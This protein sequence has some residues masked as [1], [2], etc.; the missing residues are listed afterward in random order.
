MNAISLYSGGKDGTFALYIALQQGL[1]V[2]RLVTINPKNR[3][4][5]MYHVPNVEHTKNI[6]EVIGIPLDTFYIEDSVEELTD[7]LKN[8]DSKIVI[9]G[10][11]KSEFQK[12]KIEKICTQLNK[13]SYT[14]LWYKDEILLIQ[15]IINSGFEVYISS[16]SAEGLGQEFLGAKF[17]MALLSK[18]IKLN[19]KYK[20]NISGEGGE[21]ETIALNAPFFKKRLI[22]KEYDKEW[23]GSSGIFH[24]KKLEI[25]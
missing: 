11:I 22:V 6:A 5:V 18:L 20:I 23:Q 17:D 7:L 16:V 24:I 13:I 4:S 12:T 8:Y 14:P 21:Y 3:E 19:E 2:D 9:S 25:L 1:K 15:E 10:A